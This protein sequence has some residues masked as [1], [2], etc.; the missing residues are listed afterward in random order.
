MRTASDGSAP[1]AQDCALP[2]DEATI[3]GAPSG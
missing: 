1:V 3:E 2:R